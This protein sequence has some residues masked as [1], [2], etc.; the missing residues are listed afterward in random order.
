VDRP[1]SY[2]LTPTGP[3]PRRILTSYSPLRELGE[4]DAQA[5]SAGPVIG[6]L[7]LREDHQAAWIRAG[8]AWQRLMLTADADGLAVARSPR[9]WRIPQPTGQPLPL[10][11]PA[12]TC[13]SGCRAAPLA[14]CHPPPGE[15]LR[16]TPDHS[17]SE[18]VNRGFSSPRRDDA[19][20]V[21]RHSVWLLVPLHGI[22]FLLTQ[23][24]FNTLN[25]DGLGRHSF[26][27]CRSFTEIMDEQRSQ[28]RH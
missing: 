24:R 12:S 2:H 18:L 21:Y 23:L 14:R 17:P 27:I 6:M 1:A 19:Q 20:A 3:N 15:S 25:A 16:W 22:E 5:L 7:T 9:S 11:R 26:G 8:P 4:R 13:C 10:S 28:M